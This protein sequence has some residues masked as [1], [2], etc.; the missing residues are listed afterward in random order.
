MR[1][2]G[3]IDAQKRIEDREREWES[4]NFIDAL[5]FEFWHLTFWGLDK[6]RDVLLYTSSFN[7]SWGVEYIVG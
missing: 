3:E 6:K 1:V 7:L 4:S 5:K 2:E